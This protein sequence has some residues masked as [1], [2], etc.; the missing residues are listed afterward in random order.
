MIP[1]TA[2]DLAPL[3]L[4]PATPPAAA[5]PLPA[6]SA[7]EGE[8]GKGGEGREGGKGGECEQID[9]T[10]EDERQ[11]AQEG[12]GSARAQA[13]GA[14]PAAAQEPIDLTCDSDDCAPAARKRAAVAAGNARTH[15]HKPGARALSRVRD[16]SGGGGRGR[17]PPPPPPPPAV[18]GCHTAALQD[19]GSV[20]SDAAPACV[21]AMR[22]ASAVFVGDGAGVGGLALPVL[23]APAD[24]ADALAHMAAVAGRLLRAYLRQVVS[25]EPPLH[26]EEAHGT[27]ASKAVVEAEAAGLEDDDRHLLRLV[28]AIRFVRPWALCHVLPPPLPLSTSHAQQRPGQ[29]LPPAG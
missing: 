26:A 23:P 2:D 12:G 16:G 28:G 3:S 13:A 18:A 21:W 6:L 11:P 8:D 9:L 19:G 20:P 17:A 5:P 7:S 14:A 10:S 24:N 25:E 27:A 15:T 1:L 22:E 29:G 4:S